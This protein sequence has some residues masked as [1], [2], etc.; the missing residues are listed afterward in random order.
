MTSIGLAEKF[1]YLTD[2]IMTRIEASE[3]SVNYPETLSIALTTELWSCQNLAPAQAIFLRIRNRDLYKCTDHKVIPRRHQKQVEQYITKERIVEAARALG[4]SKLARRLEADDV[5]VDFAVMHYGMWEENPLDHVKFYS[6]THPNR[7]SL[8]VTMC[9]ADIDRQ[10]EALRL[11]RETTPCLCHRSLQKC[12][13]V[14]I[15][16]TQRTFITPLC[17]TH[18]VS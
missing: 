8:R 12:Y 4:T 3:D 18:H 11:K 9:Y 6:K 14:S 2:D 13:C 17:F 5:I 10:Q 1:L 7:A 16:R 15:R